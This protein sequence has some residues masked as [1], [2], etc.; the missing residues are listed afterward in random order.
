MTAI[1]IAL[2]KL[3]DV[4]VEHGLEV[5]IPSEEISK[6]QKN[7]LAYIAVKKKEKEEDEYSKKFAEDRKQE[8]KQTKKDT[9]VVVDN[10]EYLKKMIASMNKNTSVFADL[11]VANK[12]G[13]KKQKT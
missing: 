13:G 12:I 6:K 3:A 7:A 10:Q 11:S 2:K 1:E 4:A 5:I 9:K 8:R